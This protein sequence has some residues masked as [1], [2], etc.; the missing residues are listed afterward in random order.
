MDDAVQG[1]QVGLLTPRKLVP[2]SIA[3]VAAHP[4]QRVKVDDVGV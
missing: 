2:I 3:A 4:A 1:Q